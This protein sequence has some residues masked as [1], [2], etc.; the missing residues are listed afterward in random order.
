VLGEQPL[1]ER[2]TL[3]SEVPTS[4]LLEFGTSY[5]GSRKN[6]CACLLRDGRVLVVGGE[7]S[8][9]VLPLSLE[10]EIPYSAWY[11]TIACLLK[12]GF[13]CSPACGEQSRGHSSTKPKRLPNS[14]SA[15]KGRARG[16]AGGVDHDRI[17]SNTPRGRDCSW[18]GPIAPMN[19]GRFLFA[20]GN[21][22][23]CAAAAE[24]AAAADASDNEPELILVC[25][26]YS[27]ESIRG[28]R[29]IG[30]Y[31][32]H[33]HLERGSIAACELYDVGKNEWQQ[34]APMPGPRDNHA[35]VA[36]ADGR[37]VALGGR[38]K[39]ATPGSGYYTATCV[40]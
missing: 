28:D 30:Y 25:G 37:F 8:L 1:P 14:S 22:V 3:P 40:A 17:P 20:M 10:E 6:H 2:R 21:L 12:A 23:P 27:H 13:I 24:A 31:A 36:L 7:G 39:I 34:S 26:G 9:A 11:D 19:F 15:A 4:G 18:S 5:D 38:T 29:G 32:T 16:G 33:P 35:G